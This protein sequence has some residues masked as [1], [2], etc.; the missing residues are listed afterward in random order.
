[1]WTEEVLSLSLCPHRILVG[2]VIHFSLPA[3]FED[4]VCLVCDCVCMWVCNGDCVI[5][6]NANIS[7]LGI[8]VQFKLLVA[9]NYPNVLACMF[10]CV[11]V[12]LWWNIS[13]DSIITWVFIFG[14]NKRYM[15]VYKYI[16][17]FSN[18]YMRSLTCEVVLCMVCGVFARFYEAQTTWSVWGTRD[19]GFNNL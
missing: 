4:N 10:M 8:W 19:H 15:H 5:S 2:V 16:W 12:F 9:F 7:F 6:K 13:I 11:C 18:M 3:F 1:M 17:M 14:V